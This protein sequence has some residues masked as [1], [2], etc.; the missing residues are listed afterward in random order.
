MGGGGAE[1][2]DRTIPGGRLIGKLS[3]EEELAGQFTDRDHYARYVSELPLFS[4]WQ[5]PSTVCDGLD[6]VELL[7]LNDRPRLYYLAAFAR[8]AAALGGPIA[9]LGVFRGGTALLLARVTRPA[10]SPLHLFDSFDGLSEPHAERDI[11]Y[12]RGDFRFPDADAVAGILAEAG[13]RVSIYKGWIPEVLAQ[14]PECRWAMVHVDVDLYEPT[15]AACEYFYGLMMPGAV[16]VFDEYGFPSCRGERAAVDEFFATRP[17]A[18]I[19]LPT[20]QAFVIKA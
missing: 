4:P 18:P 13:P 1:V 20:G 17:E 11:F 8:H 12:R 6:D 3:S 9:E 5:D 15:A 7:S 16:M 10:G 19:V 14:A 2:A